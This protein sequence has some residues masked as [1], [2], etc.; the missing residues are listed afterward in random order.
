MYHSYNVPALGEIMLDNPIEEEKLASFLGAWKMVWDGEE[1]VKRWQVVDNK[2]ELRGK[3]E[4]GERQEE[5]MG[6]KVNFGINVTASDQLPIPRLAQFWRESHKLKYHNQ[7]LK[8]QVKEA[9]PLGCQKLS[10][11]D[12][13]PSACAVIVTHNEAPSV[14][15]RQVFRQFCVLFLVATLIDLHTFVSVCISFNL[16]KL[17]MSAYSFS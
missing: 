8:R 10:A 12:L 5:N 14:L 3:L 13:I 7:V 4:R 6:G 17:N 1:M 2:E 15:Q 11:S 16:K 9:R